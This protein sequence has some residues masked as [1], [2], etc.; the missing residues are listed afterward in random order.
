MRTDLRPLALLLGVSLLTGCAV[1]PEYR[2]PEIDVSSRF[3]GQE[4]VA[5]RDDVQNKA[6]S[7]PK[8]RCALWKKL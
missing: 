6:V 2:S 3:L 1:G 5:H 8:S 4:G 7:L